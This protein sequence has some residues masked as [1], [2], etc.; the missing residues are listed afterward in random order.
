MRGATAAGCVCVCVCT[1]VCVCV[2]GGDLQLT[3]LV[4]RRELCHL[5]E[6]R[7]VWGDGPCP[8]PFFEGAWGGQAPFFAEDK[9]RFRT[10]HLEWRA[11]S[12]RSLPH[13]R[14]CL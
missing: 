8:L 10:P 2:G 13:P 4:I 6:T 11:A 14:P 3:A 1:R 5:E 9:V 7:W 12:A